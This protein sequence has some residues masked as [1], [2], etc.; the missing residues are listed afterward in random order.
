MSV[1][2]QDLMIAGE[3]DA[4]DVDDHIQDPES[5]ACPCCGCDNDYG[6]TFCWNCGG[7]IILPTLAERGK[8]LPIGILSGD[9]DKGYS[10]DKRFDLIPLTI[11]IERVISRS[12]AKARDSLSIAEYIGTILAYTITQV[13]DCDMSKLN[14]NKRMDKLNSMFVGDI[15]YM[16]A[17][18]RLISM[19]KQMTLNGIQCHECSHK[20]NFVADVS[21]I[22]VS[23]L[24]DPK[25]I[26]RSIKLQDGFDFGGSHRDCVIVQPARWDSMNIRV[27]FI[28]EH[29]VHESTIINS[30]VEVEGVARGAILTR[31]QYDTFSKVDVEIIKE[32]LEKFPL[33]P[34]WSI[35]GTC[36]N[37]GE[38]F[39][40]LLD[41]MY[42]SFFARSF[43]SKQQKRRR[44]K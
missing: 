41:Y 5:V 42:E 16:Y 21:S 14:V 18:L 34:R 39:F 37:C 8:R 2:I 28:T 40:F 20:F 32:E 22:G 24:E 6:A 35:E 38:H 7:N 10:L 31:N 36:P 30:I 33:G 4:K 27:G 43:T 26:E 11:P 25:T 13:G 29:E 1:S 15:F 44:K 19:G 23:V 9:K 12:W 3:R 17:Y